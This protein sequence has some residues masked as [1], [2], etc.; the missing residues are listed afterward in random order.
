MSSH[1][2]QP[3]A[4]PFF[5][6]SAPIADDLPTAADVVRSMNSAERAE[7][8]CPRE[9]QRRVESLG[10]SERFVL[11]M[12][13]IGMR[14]REIGVRQGVSAGAIA[15]RRRR[16]IKKLGVKNAFGSAP[17]RRELRQPI[18]G[19]GADGLLHQAVKSRPNSTAHIRLDGIA[20]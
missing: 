12:I 6:K 14:D 8:L 16:L 5:W 17:K 4:G 19:A 10:D 1:A 13:L 2:Q 7:E 15:A 11:Q 18:A 20:Q 9:W 3:N